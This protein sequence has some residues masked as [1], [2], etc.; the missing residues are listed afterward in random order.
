[1]NPQQGIMSLAKPDAQADR[2]VGQVLNSTTQMLSKLDNKTLGLLLQLTQYLKAHKS[3]YKDLMAN[4]EAK[5]SLPP[6]V[7]PDH[8][9]PK[10]LSV[11]A[12]SVSRAQQGGMAAGGIASIAQ[13]M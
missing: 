6:G 7:F 1:M 9:D 3:K 5:G 2:A 8:Y 13:T 4:L 11:F 12:M 10:F